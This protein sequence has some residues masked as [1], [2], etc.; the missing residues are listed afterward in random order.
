[1]TDTH[2]P[3]EEPTEGW[4]PSKHNEY[5]RDQMAA[6]R[7]TNVRRRLK[8]MADQGK[9]E[10]AGYLLALYERGVVSAVGIEL[11]CPDLPPEPKP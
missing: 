10:A 1:M 5:L 2:K 4:L 8:T 9:K 11:I 6:W 7:D 3:S